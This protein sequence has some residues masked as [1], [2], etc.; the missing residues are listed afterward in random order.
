MDSSRFDNISKGFAARHSRRRFGAASILG[1]FSLAL[2]NRFAS[3]QG[4]TWTCVFELV[5]TVAAGPNTG[6]SFQGALTLP[7]GASGAIDDGTF[8]STGGS[9][10]GVAGVATD[11][12]I[13]LRI[14]LGESGVLA[15][16]GVARRIVIGCRGEMNG[17]F[18]GPQ[19]G[20][21]G[22]WSM[23]R[24]SAAA[25]G[26][27]GTPGAGEDGEAEAT[28]TPCPLVDCG[29]TFVQNPDTCEC[30]CA[31]QS[32]RCGE[33]CC[34]GGS[35]CDEQNESCQCPAGTEICNDACIPPC[36]PGQ[37]LDQT[38]CECN[39]DCGSATCQF[40]GTIGQVL[41][42][43]TCLCVDYCPDNFPYFC[44]GTCNPE[45]YAYCNGLCYPASITNSNPNICGPGC[46]VCPS[47]V[48]CI[49]G[50]CQC[51]FGYCLTVDGCADTATD[52][53][54]CGSCGN[55]CQ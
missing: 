39:A 20:D 26:A 3:A 49:G 23:T 38:T 22:T 28:R 55:L 17:I 40:S 11:R 10:V 50:S 34:P 33:Q 18:G 27:T 44:G 15:L 12:L 48:P 52:P 35:M 54:N 21:L 5:A 8:V 42:P 2:G 14:D 25:S 45:P 1:G 41:D 46:V 7:I 43:A 31:G 4:D 16:S 32:E 30:G 9:P 36:P 29:Q 13:R 24:R 47:G 53:K 6:K 37:A 19:M 51:P